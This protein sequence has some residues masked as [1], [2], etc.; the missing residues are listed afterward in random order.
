M[1]LVFSAL[2][3][4]LGVAISPTMLR[5]MGTPPE[6]FEESYKY[7]RIYFAGATGL[8]M[9]N[10][11]VGI[12]QASG[13]SRHPLVYLVISSLVNV[14]L[15]VLFVAYLHMGVE[16][17]AFATVISQFLSMTLAAARLLRIDSIIRV[18]VKKIRFE[19]ENLMYIIRNGLPTAMH[20]CVIDLSNI[21]IQS[22]INSFG[23]LGMAGIGASTKLEGFAFLPV[24]SFSMAVTRR[25]RRSIS[26]VSTPSPGPISST[27]APGGSAAASTM[28]SRA[29]RSTRKFCPS[30]LFGWKPWSMHHALT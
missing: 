7:L 29:L 15:D 28:A 2:V 12:L 6:V 13:D 18:S 30:T 19:R 16:G 27:R 20:A 5:W 9:Y 25:P 24:T 10:M 11:F 14:A 4:V 23:N 22:Y 17:A 21:Q 1:G 26:S 3:S 8:V